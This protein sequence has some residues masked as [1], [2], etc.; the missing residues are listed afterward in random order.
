M[1]VNALS[2]CG[3]ARTSPAFV[4]RA[5]LGAALLA[6][7]AS[8]HG[9]I[10]GL[11]WQRDAASGR[12][13][14]QTPTL[15]SFADARNFA[16]SLG[17]DLA[18]VR[19]PADN[20]FLKGAFF[21]LSPAGRQHWI[22]L[23]Q[24]PA[25][26]GYSEPAGGWGWVSGE[27]LTFTNWA[28]GEPDNAGLP[29]AD[30]ARVLGS[31]AGLDSDRWD[32]VS[33][34]PLAGGGPI[35]DWY[36]GPGQTVIFN[37]VSSLL[38]LGQLAITADPAFPNNPANEPSALFAPT[39]QRTVDGGIVSVRHFY[40]EEGGVLKIEG[41][42]PFV[43]DARGDVWIRGRIIADGQ[44]SSGV[45]TLNTTNIPE[46]GAPGHAGG[47]RGGSGSPL[48]AASSPGGTAGDGAFGLPNAGGQGG[49][50]GWSTN[51]TIERRRGAGGGGG[52]T[53]ADVLFSAT[54]FD[55]RRIGYDAEPG[56]SRGALAHHVAD[57]GALSGPAGPQGG[58][59]GASPFVDG[60]PTND[61]FGVARDD[62]TG[63]FVVGELA[64]PWAGAGGGGGG[65]ASL[66]PGGVWPNPTFSPFADEKGAGGGGGGGSVRLTALGS[67]LFGD[68]GQISA[69]GG[70]GGGG[71]N[72]SFLNRVGGGSGGG[73]G[74]HVVLECATRI[75]L[76]AKSPVN[77]GDTYTTVPNSA[78]NNWAIN[79]LGGQGGAGAGDLGG[80]I[81][82]PT[83]Q[84]ETLPTNDAC[85]SG[86]PL[87]GPNACRGLV[88]GAGGDG[89]PG[90]IQLHTPKGR[91]GFNPALADILLATNGSTLASLCA[92]RPLFADGSTGAQPAHLI[93]SAGGALGLFQL[94][95]IDCDGDGQP[96]AYQIASTPS[97]D[98]DGNGVLDACESPTYCTSSISSGG[99]VAAIAG[100]GAASASASSGF[101]LV[102]S[103]LPGQ[104]AGRFFYGLSVQIAPWGPASSSYL[105]VGG[106]LQRL[107]LDFSGAAPG[108][109]NGEFRL[110]W[111]AWRAANASALGSPFAAGLVFH[112]QAWFRDPG[113]P[114]NTNLSDAVSVTLRP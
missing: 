44:S 89:G 103:S 15:M 1:F 57:N 101:E 69:R 8:A 2:M 102:A 13:Y 42:N 105:C 108:S 99:C 20:A 60:D 45:T 85:P 7:G 21:S 96:D 113:A 76:R 10:Q 50:T 24:D 52:R 25:A 80:A 53:G 109:C 61:F 77:L 112:A 83:G 79:V 32:D 36:I 46:P 43:L 100:L 55:Q 47:G 84:R 9:L 67:I 12:W 26:P 22:G 71:E 73:S 66:V 106:A 34:L 4:L 104:R 19:T 107:P 16:L 64:R 111:N 59:V 23:R 14:A 95:S 38:T 91:V 86:Y 62:A 82:L 110:D 28:P 58:A 30:V 63:R 33:Q 97:L 5:A 48:V 70:T 3:I 31:S 41:P 88:Q 93:S 35:E 40:V 78:A 51:A 65:D 74:G 11:S 72:T 87:T 54:Q 29:N 75:D 27:P 49:E 18:S 37:T 56:F 92:P 90:I 17:G 39:L 81:Q 94:D 98:S 6:S 114:R 68:A